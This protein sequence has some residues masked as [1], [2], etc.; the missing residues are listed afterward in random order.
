MKRKQD[1]ARCKSRA[2]IAA[3]CE[4][5]SELGDSFDLLLEEKDLKLVFTRR[6]CFAQTYD[7]KLRY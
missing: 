7:I 6:K 5:S 4:T 2:I 1:L 3:K